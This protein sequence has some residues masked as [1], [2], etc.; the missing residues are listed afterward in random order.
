MRDE[1]LAGLVT[2]FVRGFG[3]LQ[4]DETPCGVAVP[5][6]AAHA[7][8]E[9]ARDQPLSQIELSKRL[10]LDKSTV[11]RLLKDMEQRGWVTRRRFDGDIRY[12]RLQLT[13][14]GAMLADEVK[15]ARAAKFAHILERIPQ[16]RRELALRG[17]EVLV[18]AIEDADAQS[19]RSA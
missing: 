11:S 6:S 15:E 13:P 5:V 16:P 4:T 10:R 18:E 1:E 19:A 7:L 12:Y 8:L 14:Q 3:L 2:D 17:L 9:L